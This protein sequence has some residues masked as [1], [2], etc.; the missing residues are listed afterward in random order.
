MQ[1]VTGWTQTCI[2]RA[3][4]QSLRAQCDLD[5]QASQWFLHRTHRLVMIIICDKWILKV[6]NAG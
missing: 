3:Y 6:H 2:T 4:A 5:L 1:N